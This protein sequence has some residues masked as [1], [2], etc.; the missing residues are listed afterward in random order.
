MSTVINLSRREFLSA[1]AA[2]AGTLTLG[3]QLGV[4]GCTKDRATFVPNAFIRIGSDESVVIVVGRSEMGQG[5]HTALPMLVAEER[6]LN[7]WMPAS[8]VFFL[9]YLMCRCAKHYFPKSEER[10]VRV[11]LPCWIIAWLLITGA[12]LVSLPGD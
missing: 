3:V 9:V 8:W 7:L 5:V 1:G 12:T 11:A 10:L 4:S 6:V 2:I